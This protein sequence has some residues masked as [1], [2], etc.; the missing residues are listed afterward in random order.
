MLVS[1][2]GGREAQVREASRRF[3]RGERKKRENALTFGKR[4]AHGLALNGLLAR[5]RCCFCRVVKLGDGK[6]DGRVSE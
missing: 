5:H 2:G 4:D 6:R 1:S 3:L